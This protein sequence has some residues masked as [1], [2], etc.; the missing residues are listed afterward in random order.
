MRVFLSIFLKAWTLGFSMGASWLI[1][2]HHI[3]PYPLAS[4]ASFVSHQE[5]VLDA[6]VF[7]SE[8]TARSMLYLY[9][10][11]GFVDRLMSTSSLPFLPSHLG[12]YI[13]LLGIFHQADS[14]KKTI[15]QLRKHEL[16]YFSY[17]R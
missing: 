6:G 9:A 11:E 4:K 16:P 7:E 15:L 5:Y 10:K 1:G 3:A 8:Q 13:V 14:M 12:N 17:Q 2:L